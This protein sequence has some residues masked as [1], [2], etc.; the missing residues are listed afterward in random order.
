MTNCHLDVCS[1]SPDNLG[2]I[3]KKL[4]ANN[5]TWVDHKALQWVRSKVW[6]IAPLSRTIEG[7]GADAGG[8]VE[9]AAARAQRGARGPI[10]ARRISRTARRGEN[11]IRGSEPF[12]IFQL[13]YDVLQT[14][15]VAN[16]IANALNTTLLRPVGSE[17]RSETP[18][19]LNFC[20]DSIWEIVMCRRR[21]QN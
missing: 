10:L 6:Q 17:R 11:I 14:S 9:Q 20:S 16:S 21:W 15:W 4:T 18:I 13:H 5:K 1:T 8:G 2:F 12:L 3:K 19:Y 7:G